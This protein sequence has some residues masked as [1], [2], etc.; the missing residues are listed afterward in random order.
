MIL[1]FSYCIY[2][3]LK[4]LQGTT[5]EKKLFITLIEQAL[6]GGDDCEA[7]ELLTAV[8]G[9]FTELTVMLCHADFFS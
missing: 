9:N 5:T 8:I 2:P 6:P 4:Q 3:F 1:F 7:E